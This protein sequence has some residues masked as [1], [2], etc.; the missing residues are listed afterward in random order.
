MMCRGN[1][2]KA[3]KFVQC[4]H[5]TDTIVWCPTWINA[6]EGPMPVCDEHARSFKPEFNPYAKNGEFYWNA[7]ANE[8]FARIGGSRATKFPS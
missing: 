6:G 4:G 1:E 2:Y 3:G 8:A 5:P 7:D